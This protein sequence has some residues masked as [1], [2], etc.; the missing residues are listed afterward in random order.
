VEIKA[1]SQRLVSPEILNSARARFQIRHAKVYTPASSRTS[2]NDFA[3]CQYTTVMS[4]FDLDSFMHDCLEH[5]RI[6]HHG[7]F[8]SES[9]SQTSNNQ[10]L[11]RSQSRSAARKWKRTW[12]STL[13]VYRTR[14]C[15]VWVSTRT[16]QDPRHDGL[17]ITITY[18]LLASEKNSRKK[19]NVIDQSI[20]PR[21][22]S[23]CRHRD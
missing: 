11:S 15:L 4:S 13:S 19:V 23:E 1:C 5:I 7:S 12:L 22:A 17:T 16:G 2:Q 3:Y 21:W 6:W 14:Q 20:A 18:S 10:P 9:D 8:N